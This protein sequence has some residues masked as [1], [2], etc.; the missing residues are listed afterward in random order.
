MVQRAWRRDAPDRLGS[1]LEE[2]VV[3]RARGEIALLRVRGAGVREIA[4]SSIARP[5]R[6]VASCDASST[7]ANAPPDVGW[8]TGHRR[9]R[10]MPIARLCARNRRG[11]RP[12]TGC[13]T[14][15][16]PDWSMTTVPSRSP[17]DCART[18]PTIRRCGCRTR[19]STSRSTSRAVVRSSASW[20]S[21]CAPAGP[22]ASPT[23]RVTSGRERF[24]EM[25]MISE[26]PAE[27]EDRAVPGHWEGD[28]ILGSAQSGSAVGTLVERTT[29]S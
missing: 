7:M 20:P 23:A 12:T 25:V 28:L 14:R 19:R 5:R 3:R 22:Y 11:W 26:R 1:S 21:T 6:S 2:L 4:E 17:D 13:A 8:S 18:S 15:C 24:A 16:S 10:P 9:H 29:G 27:V